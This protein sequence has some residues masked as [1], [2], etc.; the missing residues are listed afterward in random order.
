ME[1]FGPAQL[2][3]I[4]KMSAI[5]F[6]EIPGEFR[7]FLDNSGNSWRIQEI[8]GDFLEILGDF[9]E[10]SWADLSATKESSFCLSQSDQ[11]VKSG[12]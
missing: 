9:L 2:S 4:E 6:P 3:V 11:P 8:P 12:V 1:I 5:I 7:K 10:I